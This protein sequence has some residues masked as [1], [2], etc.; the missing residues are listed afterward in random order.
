MKALSETVKG[1][2]VVFFNNGIPETGTVMRVKKD[3]TR[4]VKPD[5]PDVNEGCYVDVRP[6][7]TS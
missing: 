3:G 7:V 2:R 1:D 6:R 5:S 4:T